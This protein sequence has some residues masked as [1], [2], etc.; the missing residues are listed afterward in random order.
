MVNKQQ[1]PL[2]LLLLLHVI[3]FVKIC[4]VE[5]KLSWHQLC[6]NL[7]S[8]SMACRP[9]N[10]PVSGGRTTVSPGPTADTW[11]TCGDRRP[12]LFAVADTGS[13]WRSRTCPPGSRRWPTTACTADSRLYDTCLDYN[14][15]FLK[16][17]KSY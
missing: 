10:R 9:H 2:N 15:I 4:G 3:Y 6:S 14:F 1:Y 8:S 7:L 13:T 16:V 17:G 5:I 11:D 12:S